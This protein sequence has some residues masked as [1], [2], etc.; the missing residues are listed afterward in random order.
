V[1][2]ADVGDAR[3][4]AALSGVV[5]PISDLSAASLDD[6]FARAVHLKFARDHA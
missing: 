6:A 2:A 5:S 1:L 3:E 4:S